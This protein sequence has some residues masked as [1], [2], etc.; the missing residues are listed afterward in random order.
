MCS[1]A[2]C[3]ELRF[4]THFLHFPTR[5]GT[6]SENLAG[7]VRDSAPLLC[8]ARGEKERGMRPAEHAV[9]M[10]M[11]RK[12]HAINNGRSCFK[13]AVSRANDTGRYPPECHNP[14]S[15]FY[16]CDYVAGSFER[17]AR[18]MDKR[19]ARFFATA[20]FT[21]PEREIHPRSAC[22]CAPGR[23]VPLAASAAL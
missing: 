17:P 8:R 16:S 20:R 19:N 12:D 13:A 10:D 15:T 6:M 2:L 1:R 5:R 22:S 21:G 18:A 4:S 3:L 7:R 14:P 11:E 23:T 9:R